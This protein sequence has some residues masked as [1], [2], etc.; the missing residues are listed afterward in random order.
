MNVFLFVTDKCKGCAPAKKLLQDLGV[1]FLE[2]RKQDCGNLSWLTQTEEGI[3]YYP[4]LLIQQS[5]N[6]EKP[7]IIEGYAKKAITKAIMEVYRWHGE[8]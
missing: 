4:T 8:N 1:N 2:V 5:L 6:G 3:R 7:I